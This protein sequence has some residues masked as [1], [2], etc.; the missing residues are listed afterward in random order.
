M[1]AALIT[2]A[3]IAALI[4]WKRDKVAE[5]TG[6]AA[7]MGV[8]NNN[9]LNIRKGNDWQGETTPDHNR[10]YEAFISPEYGFRAGAKILK[11][12]NRRGIN[13]IPA[14]IRTFAPK[15]D[16]NDPNH[17]T[18]MVAK[19]TGFDVNTPVDVDNPHVLAKLLQAMAR[20]E[21]GR[22]YPLSTVMT[23]VEMA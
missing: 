4:F 10:N 3:V 7:P 20:M 8:R 12:Y 19:W 18:N 2:G 5:M 17:Y 16:N 11:S 15:E 22:V 23:G 21:V 14:I 13:T 9:P 6:L 1:K